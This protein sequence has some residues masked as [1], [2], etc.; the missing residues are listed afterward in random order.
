MEHILYHINKVYILSYIE[1]VSILG[2]TFGCFLSLLLNV[3]ALMRTTFSNLAIHTV[4]LGGGR[5]FWYKCSKTLTPTQCNK[6]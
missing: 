5:G 1:K 6:K 3:N 2:C 4:D